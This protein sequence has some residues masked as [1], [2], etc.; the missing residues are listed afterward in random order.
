M[1]HILKCQYKFFPWLVPG[2]GLS[3]GEEIETVWSKLRYLWSKIREMSISTREDAISDALEQIN[4]LMLDELPDILLRQLDRVSSAETLAQADLEELRRIFPN[5]PLTDPDLDGINLEV[6]GAVI[7]VEWQAR[8]VR[9]LLELKH[10]TYEAETMEP[11]TPEFTQ[12]QI[13]I[14]KIKKIVEDYERKQGL[15][16]YG[17]AQIIRWKNAALNEWLRDIKDKL[18]TN[19]VLENHYRERSATYRKYCV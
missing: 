13:R 6:F 8:Y 14:R 7:H 11:D 17:E 9:F 1:P 16:R 5:A 12:L 18:R 15:C 2:N 3:P 10:L 4:R 19:L